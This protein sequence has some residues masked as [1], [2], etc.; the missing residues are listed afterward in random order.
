[1]AAILVKDVPDELRNLFKAICAERGKSMRERIIEL[2]REAIDD[3]RR[4]RR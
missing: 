1:M 2:M 3:R 4:G